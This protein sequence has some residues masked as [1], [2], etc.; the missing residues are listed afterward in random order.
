MENVQLSSFDSSPLVKSDGL[1]D[2]DKLLA[3]DSI[4]EEELNEELVNVAEEVAEAAPAKEKTIHG[5]PVAQ[6]DRIARSA[7]P[8]GMTLSKEA[9]V[10]LQQ[11]AT[12]AVLYLGAMASNEH[13]GSGGTK[14]TQKAKKVRSTLLPIDVLDGLAAGGWSHI[15]PEIQMY[16]RATTK[17]A[18][19]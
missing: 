14:K 3:L 8:E 15:I 19:D 13:E 12:V 17:R 1:I 5:I 11:A 7:L 16:G 10:M 9:K 2:D 4:A 18:R 6:V